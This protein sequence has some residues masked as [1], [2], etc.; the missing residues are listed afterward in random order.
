MTEFAFP[1]LWRRAVDQDI[2]DDPRFAADLT[3]ILARLNEPDARRTALDDLITPSAHDG[4][5]DRYDAAARHEV[6]LL[7]NLGWVVIARISITAS[8]NDDPHCRAA[9]ANRLPDSFTIQPGRDT[10]SFLL[11]WGSEITIEHAALT[12]HSLVV[13]YAPASVPLAMDRCDPATIIYALRHLGGIA[14]GSNQH[15]T[16][17]LLL[18]TCTITGQVGPVGNPRILAGS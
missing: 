15:D 7:L 6:G 11:H 16:V 5:Y 14:R 1:D 10:D 8:P 4:R 9:V 18:T 3:A 13:A 12:A 2:A 17:T